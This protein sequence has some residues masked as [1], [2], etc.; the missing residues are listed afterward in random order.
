MREP[1]REKE[2][3]GPEIGGSRGLGWFLGVW[4]GI[5]LR[6]T[7]Q[8]SAFPKNA[9]K[10]LAFCSMMNLHTQQTPSLEK[11]TFRSG[12]G[13]I[14]SRTPYPSEKNQIKGGKHT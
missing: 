9:L 2:K 3:T 8:V 4:K 14:E 5:F 6:T 1:A 7:P 11:H 12:G 10:N 13:S